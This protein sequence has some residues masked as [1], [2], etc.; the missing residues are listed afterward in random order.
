MV[1]ERNGHG[2][3]EKRSQYQRIR[4]MAQD[5]SIPC[6]PVTHHRAILSLQDT[7]SVRCSGGVSLSV[8]VC[9]CVCMCVCV[10]L[11]VCVEACLFV[12]KCM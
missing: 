8:C 1:L 6:R 7:L 2:V 5:S 10:C 9:V 4:V 12:F 11:S 3:R